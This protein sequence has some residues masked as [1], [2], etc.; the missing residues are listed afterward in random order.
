MASN[1]G[2]WKN[3]ATNQ[4]AWKSAPSEPPVPPPTGT[5]KT[6]ASSLNTGITI[7]MS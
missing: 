3:T 2:A 6:K 1:Q 4:G 7:G 5:P